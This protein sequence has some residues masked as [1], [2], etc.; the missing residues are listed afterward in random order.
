M[1]IH[2]K[3]AA[4]IEAEMQRTGN[5]SY[6]ARNVAAR[7]TRAPK[8]HQPVGDL[9]PRWVAE[10]GEVGWSVEAIAQA[11]DREAAE[12][13]R[14]SPTLSAEEVRAVVNQV[15][16]ADGALAARKVFTRR[17]VVVAVAPS[18]YGRDPSE[19]TRVVDRTLADPEAVPL[20]GVAGASERAYATAVTIAREEAIA[21]CVESQ[22][23]RCNAAATSVADARAAAARAEERLGHAMTAGQRDAV[24]AVCTSGRG[25]DL[26]VGVAGSGKTTALAAARDAFEA[27]GYEVVGTSTS[28]QAARTLS[29][30][31]G[32]DSRT[33]ASLNWRIA[34]DTLRLSPRHV[35]VLD[36]AAM[37]DDAALVAFLEAAKVAGAKVVAVGDPRQLSSVG[38]GGGFEAVVRRF[39]GS[40]HVLSENVRQVDVAEREALAQLRSGKVDEAVSWYAG[41]GRIAASPD[42]DTALD[43]TVAGWVADVAKGGQAAMYAWRRAD[44]AELNRRG[45][46]AWDKLGRL[47]G[48]ELTVG[49]MAYRTG[50]RIVTLAP[51]AGGEIVTSECGTVL[52]VDVG[53]RELAATMDDG[54]LQ[55]FGPDELDAAHLA[56]SYAITVHRAQG[57][58]VGR[59]HVYEDGGGREL[60]YVKMSRARERST[61]YTVADS[62]EQA[63]EDLGRT[64]SPSRRIGWAIDQGTPAPGIDAEPVPD[65]PA[66][67]ASLRHARLV[68]E[69]EAVAAVVPSDPSS[70]F[71][72]TRNTVD[73]LQRKLEDL[74]NAEGWGE[75]RGTPLGDAAIAWRSALQEQRGSLAQAEH[76]GLRERHRLRQQAKRAA[77]QIGPLR[78]RFEALAGPE[79]ARLKVELP[80]A[81]RNL[82]D[83]QGRRDAYMRF[84]H[85]H[86]E[87]LRRLDRLDDQI[88]TAA[89]DLGVERQGL[90]GIRPEPPESSAQRWVAERGIRGM[91]RGIDLGIDL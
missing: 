15:L 89:W 32:I 11:V 91:D 73:R 65:A 42:R 30:E 67:S 53:R 21:R 77:E 83:L 49:E 9:M 40:V 58:T 81:K 41:A 34:H 33:L 13:R 51:G 79:R 3:R 14:P 27:A 70:A 26:V 2:S 59:A 1:D 46:E 55:R 66:V 64:W 16:D 56:H 47:S 75:W 71:Y 88:A 36:E 82:A 18:L 19:L 4:E 72:R 12:R 37:T 61:V 69:R 31:A 57:A 78:E 48:K 80:D 39:G 25:V 29:R 54:R 84:Q 50:D 7:T 52:A 8:R 38:P 90:D 43:A 62:V 28:G 6:Q 22:V 44:V 23:T 63:A 87:A 86:P 68:A 17:D 60:A 85:E 5:S 76:V 74:D 24:E 10:I 20:L 45:R 35:A